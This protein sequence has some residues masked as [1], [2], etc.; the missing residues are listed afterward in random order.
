MQKEEI[1]NLL[2]E[3]KKE[4]GDKDKISETLE[5][6][7]QEQDINW[8]NN[9]LISQEILHL[10]QESNTNFVDIGIIGHCLIEQAHSIAL[11]RL[12]IGRDDLSVYISTILGNNRLNNNNL[13]KKTKDF[14]LLCYTYLDKP[15]LNM[16]PDISRSKKISVNLKRRF[17]ILAK[18]N[19]KCF[20]CG[21]SPPEVK[22]EL[23]HINPK[24]KGGNNDSSNL[25]PA[26]FECNSGKRDRILEEIMGDENDK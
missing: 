8:E 14:L 23:E 20:Y 26:C 1:V 19:F 17:S 13:T 10:L 11:N 3:F 15:Q 5:K 2:Y 21:R 9:F 24:S 7:N 16:H 4:G 18:N 6:V 22:L 25:V 12:E